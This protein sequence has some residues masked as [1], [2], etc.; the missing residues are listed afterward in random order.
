[1]KTIISLLTRFIPRRY[2]QV[3]S[4]FILRMISVF[5]RGKEKECPVCGRT[6]RKFMPYGRIV[7]RENALCPSCLSLERHRLMWL[8]LKKKT[9]FFTSE[10]KVLHVAPEYCF[11]KRFKAL[12]NLEYIT[13]D[14]ESPLADV[15]MDIRETPIEDDTFNVIIYNHTLEHVVEDHQAMKEFYRVLKPG[16]WGILNVPI[17]EK[18]KETYEDFSITDPNEREKH[19]GQRDHVREYG[20]DYTDRLKNA[21][22]TVNAIDLITE[23]GPEQAERFALLHYNIKTAEDQIFLVNKK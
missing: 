5:Y 20:L 17:N 1:M 16:G 18:R 6:F 21:G 10:L 19:F 9:D 8:F 14:I 7:K 22:F 2:L 11:I 12:E 4:H 15:K 23:I 3:V 13:G